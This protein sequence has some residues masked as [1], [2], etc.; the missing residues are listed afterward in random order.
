MRGNGAVVLFAHMTRLFEVARALALVGACA[1]SLASASS[2]SSSPPPGY[3]GQ[4][5]LSPP[6]PQAMQPNAALGLWMSS[7]GAVKIGEDL[8][9]GAAGSG[10]LHGAWTYQDQRSGREIVGYFSGTLR[11]NVLELRW[12][13][14]A[15]PAPLVGSA[16]LVFD[17]M[18]SRFSG[19]WR[20][21][22]G[23][24]GGEWSGWRDT[25]AQPSTPQPASPYPAQPQPYPAQ[26]YPAQPQPYSPYP[27]QPYP[28]QPYPAQPQPYSPYPRP[29]Q[30]QPYP[31]QPYPAQPQ[32]YPAQ[33]YPAQPQPTSPYSQPPPVDPTEPRY[34]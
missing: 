24:R 7:F 32:P 19:R 12:Q 33:P 14:P 17:P 20:T 29:P 22:T 23:D 3:A 31:A 18:G 26:P 1:A 5:G 8:S 27:T 30:P 2:S 16:Y 15:L 21:D 34:Y 28:A 25:G 11:G 6:P 10:N 4:Q 9:R 13:E